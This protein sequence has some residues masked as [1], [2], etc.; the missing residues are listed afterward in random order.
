MAAEKWTED[1]RIWEGD[2]GL[3]DEEQIA[4]CARADAAEPFRSPVP[5]RVISN[6]EYMPA[7]QTERQKRVEVRIQEMADDASKRLGVSR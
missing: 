4:K 6:G 3:L 7:L 1:D 2:H 5:T